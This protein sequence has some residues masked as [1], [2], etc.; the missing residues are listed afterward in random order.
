MNS[1]SCSETATSDRPPSPTLAATSGLLY[2]RPKSFTYPQHVLLRPRWSLLRYS[3]RRRI[4]RR[5][6]SNT[7]SRRSPDQCHS[8]SLRRSL[9][10]AQYVSQ[11]CPAQYGFHASIHISITASHMTN[12]WTDGEYSWLDSI[13]R[14]RIWRPT[15]RCEHKGSINKSRVFS[16]DTDAEYVAPPDSHIPRTGSGDWTR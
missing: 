6:S 14:A 2:S 4:S 12:I 3:I 11:A 5:T 13:C 16:T 8:N 15:R 10:R 9:P 7:Y 1:W